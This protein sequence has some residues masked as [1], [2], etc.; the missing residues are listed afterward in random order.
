MKTVRIFLA[1]SAELQPDRQ[2]FEIFLSRRS[3]QWIKERD[4]YLELVVWENFIDAMSKTRLQDEYNKAIR[5]SDIFVM[6]FWNKVGKF[7]EEEFKVAYDAFK[8]NNKP[9]VYTF[10]KREDDSKTGVDETLTNFTK[11]LSGELEHY[12]TVY[13]NTDGLLLQF[14]I[15]LDKL[16]PLTKAEAEEKAN[17]QKISKKDLKDLINQGELSEAFDQ[18]NTYFRNNN[19]RLNALVFEFVNPPNNFNPAMYNTRLK[20]FIDQSWK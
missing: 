9:L 13:K 10:L 4:I 12:K 11:K 6:L 18:M 1:S 7:T 16:Y 3:S 8:I 5:E 15:Q 17:P 19:D 20:V 2:A 14:G